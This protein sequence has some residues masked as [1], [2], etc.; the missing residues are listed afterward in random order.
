MCSI[1][2]FFSLWDSY[3]TTFS[4]SVEV[5]LHRVVPAALVDSLV[6]FWIL[7]S[8]I[9]TIE[10]L[11]DKKQSSKVA[12]FIRLRNVIV[13]VVVLATAYNI[14]FSYLIIENVLESLWKLQWFF[15]EGVWSSFY[16]FILCAITV[17]VSPASHV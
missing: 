6:Y 14:G 7:Q 15:S 2:F 3:V 11:S 13:V 8:L 17:G 10:D 9:S 1:Y 12:V 5:D 16:F 4:S